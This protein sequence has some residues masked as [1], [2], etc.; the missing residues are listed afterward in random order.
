MSSLLLATLATLPLGLLPAVAPAR[1]SG[2]L[3]S[4]R[5]PPASRCPS[6]GSAWSCNWCSPSAGL[7]PSSGRTTPGY[8]DLAD[9]LA[10][11]VLPAT[12]LAAV[13]AAAWS[14]YLR[15]SVSDTLRQPFVAAARAAAPARGW[16]CGSTPCGPH[17]CPS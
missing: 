5:P 16:C 9:R 8:G 17:C 12:M 10:H 13:H 3:A 4:T 11:L 6:S 1:W 15:A 7:A 14:R 2:R